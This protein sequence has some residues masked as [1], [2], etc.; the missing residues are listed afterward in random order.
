[1]KTKFILFLLLAFTACQSSKLDSA[2]LIIFGG[3][4]YIMEEDMPVA[5]AVVIK[6][7]KI[8]FVGDKERAFEFKGNDTELLDLKSKMMTPSFIEGHGYFMGLGFSELNLGLTTANNYQD[9]IN[10]VKEA[11]KIAKPGEWILGREWHQSKWNEMPD[12]MVKEFQTHDL[13][14]SESPNNPVYLIHASGHAGF[15]NAKAMELA[16]VLNSGNELIIECGEIIRYPDGKPTG[17]FNERSQGL[18]HKIIPETSSERN[19]MAFEKEILACQ[20]NRITSFQN[21]GTDTQTLDYFRK[22]KE[23]KKLGVRMYAML[24]SPDP[25]LLKEW[26]DKGPKVDMDNLLTKRSLK[27]HTDGAL[28]SRGA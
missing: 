12:M 16:G 22:I 2:D 3:Q 17:I 21:S 19:G 26:F 18:I 20:R 9:I 7:E 1:M 14:S 24:S 11:V 25:L 5:Q 8:I 6:D 27:I 4:V 23:E 10:Q 28:G 15:A 13:L